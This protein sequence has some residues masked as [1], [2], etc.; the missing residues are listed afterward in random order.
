MIG[1]VIEG[2]ETEAAFDAPDDHHDVRGRVLLVELRSDGL[3]VLE[4]RHQLLAVVVGV[5]EAL[6]AED[7]P[8]VVDGDDRFVARCANAV[9]VVVLDLLSPSAL[10]LAVRP[11]DR[12][13][14]RRSSRPWRECG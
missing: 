2:L 14:G 11:S 8:G 6:V 10:N 12:R 9:R 4:E 5:T 13:R 7:I 1:G 3:G